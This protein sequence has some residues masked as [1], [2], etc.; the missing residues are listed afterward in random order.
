MRPVPTNR[1]TDTGT[2]ETAAMSQPY[3]REREL[4]IQAV[5]TAA[6][7]CHSVRSGLAPEV[8]AKADRSPVTVADFGSQ[9]LVGRAL[10]EAFPD[11]PLIAEEDAAELR[12]AEN[13]GL[14]A[15][16]VA[17]VQT[18]QP[19]A[20]C[21]S[22]SVAG[23]TAAARRRSATGSGPSTR[24]TAPRASSATSSTPSPWP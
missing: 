2:G 21:R 1:W 19:D 12:R 15:E 22:G 17:Q 20:E 24:S 4:A 10:A 9:A 23:S 13:A 8:L 6:A 11:D 3:Q 16:V 14:L 5:R 18:L 7:L